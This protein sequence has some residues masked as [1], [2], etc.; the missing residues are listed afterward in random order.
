MKKIDL[1]QRAKGMILQPKAEWELIDREEYTVK[2]LYTNYVLILAAIPAIAGFLGF[3]IVGLGGIFSTYRVPI[4]SGIAHMV[5]GY[6]SSLVTVYLL[7]L[8]IDG[9]APTFDAQKNFLQAMKLAVFSSTPIWLAGIFALLPAFTI[10]ALLGLYGFYLLFL[11]LPLLMN[12]SAD[13]AIP[14]FVVIVVIAIVLHVV[15]RAVIAL[16]IPG[17]LRGF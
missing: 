12:T 6:L 11:G 4:P 15:V 16:A 14:Y 8:V 9:F 7:A 5:L 2:D 1:V 17:P 13:K 3:S 10:L